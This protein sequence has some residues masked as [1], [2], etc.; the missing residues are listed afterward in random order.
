MI[1][2]VSI[3]AVI[4]A[5][6]LLLSFALVTPASA[7][8]IT[9]IEFDNGDIT[10]QGTGGSTVNATFRV[11]VGPNEVVEIF[12]T[13]VISDKLGPE[14]FSVG[15]N[16]GLEE[17][18]HYVDATIQLPPN[19]GTYKVTAKA[20]GIYGSGFRA[21]DC[22]SNVVASKPF[23]NALKTVSSE[24][25]STGG[26]SVVSDVVFGG[27]NL[28]DLWNRIQMLAQSVD[29]LVEQQE[30][31]QESTKED[32]PAWCSMFPTYLAAATPWKTTPANTAL[33]SL[34]IYQGGFS[35]IITYGATSYYGE[36]TSRAVT[37]AHAAC[38]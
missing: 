23:P 16:N 13:D 17:G 5:L 26:S 32:T 31:A 1:K 28:T 2:S 11:V 8:S 15:G 4:S 21:S 20:C 7:A 33:Q 24:S 35:H 38:N 22:E 37:A 14:H 6:V 10:A 3:S 34:L 29:L 27:I 12:Q 9:N 19:T 18:V 25:T 36:Q 30:Q